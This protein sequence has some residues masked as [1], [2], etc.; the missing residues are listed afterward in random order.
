MVIF[1]GHLPKSRLS[2]ISATVFHANL[3]TG[4][5]WQRVDEP[6]WSVGWEPCGILKSGLCSSG[7][8]DGE[9][10]VPEHQDVS[11]VCCLLT[12]EHLRISTPQRVPQA[13]PVSTAAST[14]SSMP[15][16]PAAWTPRFFQLRKGLWHPE[17]VCLWR[18]LQ[19]SSIFGVIFEASTSLA[20]LFLLSDSPSWA[21]RISNRCLGQD[22]P[23]WH[24]STQTQATSLERLVLP[25]RP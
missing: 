25:S 2:A 14:R 9:A 15:S 5:I 6:L 3:I 4:N 11:Q 10:L 8:N 22:F 18:H 17:D 12:P 13:P 16:S 23:V 21:S 20:S 1:G 19:G 24:S 7:W